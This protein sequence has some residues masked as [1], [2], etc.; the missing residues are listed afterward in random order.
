MLWWTGD[1]GVSTTSRRYCLRNAAIGLAILAAL[2]LAGLL[3]APQL[4]DLDR[5]KEAI[6]A[7][8][9]AR[10]GRSVDLVGPIGLSLL[11]SPTIT[12]RNVHLANPPGAAVSDMV[13]LRAVEVKLAFWPLLSGDLQIPSVTLIEPE[14]DLEELPGGANN[15]RLQPSPPT[16]PPENLASPSSSALSVAIDHLTIQNGAVTYRSAGAVERFEHINATVTLDNFLGPFHAT[17]DFVA[18]GAALSI[19]VQSGKLGEP[20]IPLQ[21]TVTTKPAAR[22]QIDA[23]LT[24]AAGDRRIDGKVKITADDF[25]AAAGTLARAPLPSTLAVPFALAGDLGGSL[26]DVAFDHMAIDLGPAHAEGSARLTPG[27]P[28]SLDLALAVNRLD[29][30]HWTPARKATLAPRSSS[31]SALAATIEPDAAIPAQRARPFGGFIVPPG[32]DISIELGV[33]GI[34]W[35]NGLI[36]EARLKATLADGQITLDR[37]A[38]LLPGGSD[39]AASGSGA[40]TRDGAHAEGVIEANADDLRGLLAWLGVATDA[41]PPDRLR[42]ASISTH[43]ALADDRLD[44]ADID[45]TL[46]ATRLS[47]AA[48]IV[49]RDRPGVGLRLAADRFNLDAYLPRAAATSASPA[50]SPPAGGSGSAIDGILTAFDTN[51]DARLGALTW[52]GQS[53][54]D[55]HLASTIQNGEA[56]IRELSVGDIGGASGKLSGVIAGLSRGAPTGQLAFD[57]RGPEFERVLRVVSPGL[58]AGRNYG[59]FDLGGGLQSDGGGFA[60]DT[61]LR[62]L[63][64]HARIAGT[65][66]RTDGSA[67]LALTA[68]HPSFAR[69]MTVFSPAYRPAGGDPGPVTFAGHLKGGLT[70][71]N[72]EALSLVIGQSTLDGMLG[73]TLA[74]ERPQLVADFKLGDWSIDRLLTARRTAMR[75]DGMRRAGLSPGMILVQAGTANGVSGGHW[76]NEPIDLSALTLAD[77]DLTLTANSVIYGIWR[78]DHPSLTAALREGV[79]T[80]KQLTGEIFGGV[81][82]ARGDLESMPTPT[83]HWGG[84][85]KNVDLQTAL[86][87]AGASGIDGR[88]DIDANLASGGRSPAEVVSHLMG[89]IV[90]RGRDG[91]I[92]GIDIKALS[93]RLAASHRP[94]DLVAPVGENA[95]N[96]TAVSTL[97]GTFHVRDGIAE[98]DDIH[99]VAD[100]GEGQA[101]ASLDLPAWTMRGRVEFQLAGLPTLPPLTMRLDG[102]INEPRKI[103]EIK[104]LEQFLGQRRALKGSAPVH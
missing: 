91:G 77:V 60:V 89:D 42:K 37:L 40:M 102:P 18:R 75:E 82:D 73:V 12:A 11:P 23:T 70:H 17:G 69:L 15:W 34:L 16:A 2:V 98:S 65:I 59:A 10:T 49:L 4:V 3:L 81:V 35:R 80:A 22:L 54:G 71:V 99:L 96:R 41:V 97:G 74:G 24:G 32:I 5:F 103:L 78:L 95:E 13:R 39:A 25:Q 31:G 6:A 67:D 55:L 90:F 83:L 93:D 44:L 30:D 87:A 68:D 8:I 86:A 56:M 9:A 57:M 52:R 36:R 66:T 51:L 43:I 58:A 14:I 104:A 101:I 26:R 33:E 62:M 47:G 72:V 79:L 50:A 1:V 38:A 45:A 53:L 84:S 20:E 94:P 61:E 21:V 48:T 100:G 88:A 63:D 76:S 85:L 92:S 7:Q 29:L 46:D 27:A 28:L 19:D 64:G